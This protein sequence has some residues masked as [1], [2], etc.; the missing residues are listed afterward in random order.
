MALRNRWIVRASNPYMYSATG[1]Y[2]VECRATCAV[3]FYGSLAECRAMARRLHAGD[4]VMRTYVVVNVRTGEGR[5]I[6]STDARQAAR[7]ANHQDFPG[8]DF[9]SIGVAAVGMSYWQSGDWLTSE[10]S[11]RA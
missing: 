3:A 7:K 8:V 10:D 1:P 9:R 5:D 4:A 6:E 2:C 11:R